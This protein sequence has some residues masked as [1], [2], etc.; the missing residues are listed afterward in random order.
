MSDFPVLAIFGTS[1]LVG[2]SGALSPG[3]TLAY[4]IRESVRTGFWAGPM[5]SLGHSLLELVVVIGL[6]LGV[7]QI[8]ENSLSVALIGLV[9][10]A[11]LL[12]MGWGMLRHPDKGAP[13][14]DGASQKQ[15][16]QRLYVPFL[17]GIGMSLSNPFWFVWWVTVGAAFMTKSLEVG[18]VGVAA[19][20]LGHIVADIGWYTLVSFGVASGRRFVTPRLYKAIM[21]ACGTFIIFLGL[22][23]AATGLQKLT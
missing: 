3:P 6:A 7:A 21:Q 18:A 4:T 17:G 10:G 16:R 8:T 11:F 13:A 12:W 1:F 5:V 14:S 20:Y 23:F 9:G 19:F 22:Y 2:L 15:G